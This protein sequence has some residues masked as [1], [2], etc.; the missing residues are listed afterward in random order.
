MEQLIQVAEAIYRYSPAGS[1]ERQIALHVIQ[2]IVQSQS[3]SVEQQLRVAIVPL[4][5]RRNNF[6]D[7]ALA[8]RMILTLMQGEEVKN[9]LA[10][11]WNSMPFNMERVSA[12]QTTPDYEA[13]ISDIPSAVYLVKQDVVP[14]AARDKMYQLLSDMV[15]LFGNVVAMGN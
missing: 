13:F 14:E 2:H 11:N 15:P 1:D 5:V 7:R 3:A 4:T 6:T 12:E 8:L 10:Q 9:L